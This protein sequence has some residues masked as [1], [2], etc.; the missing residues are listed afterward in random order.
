M[1]A[2]GTLLLQALRQMRG[3]A[4]DPALRAMLIA[5]LIQ[6]LGRGIVDIARLIEEI[7]ERRERQETRELERARLRQ[8]LQT[9]EETRAERKRSQKIENIIGSRII[10]AALEALNQGKPELIFARL[11]D[12]AQKRERR[13]CPCLRDSIRSSS[14]CRYSRR[15]AFESAFEGA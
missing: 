1:A 10:P 9:T 12:L 11:R 3:R 14:A 15:K 6:Q 7:R 4:D 8:L 13:C 2:P 5:A